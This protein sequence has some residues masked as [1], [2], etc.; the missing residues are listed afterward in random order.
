MEY[1]HK[2]KVVVIGVLER[3]GTVR[4]EIVGDRTRPRCR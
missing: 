4:T 2:G 3:G 1:R